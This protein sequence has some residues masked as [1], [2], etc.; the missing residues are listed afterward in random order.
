M[1]RGAGNG[2]VVGWSALILVRDA[3]E[4]LVRE[5]GLVVVESGGTIDRTMFEGGQAVGR[6]FPTLATEIRVNLRRG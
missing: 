5:V 2:G 3:L 1:E 6:K 4:R